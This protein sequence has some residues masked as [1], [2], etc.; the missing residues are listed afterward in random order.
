[1]QTYATVTNDI[2]LLHMASSVLKHPWLRRRSKWIR[3][4]LMFVQKA[5]RTIAHPHPISL[6]YR[7]WRDRLIFQRFW[8]A[9][10]LAV[11][12]M[13]IQGVA[14][15]Y[16]TFVNPEALLKNLE[17]RKLTYLLETFRQVFILNKVTTIG[18]LGLLILF[19]NSAWGRKYPSLLVILFP[20]AFSFLPVMVLS[21][22][23]GI[24]A[25]PDIIMFMAQVAILPIHWR[26]HLV[27]QVV[28]IAFYFIVYPLIGLDTFGGLTIYSFSDTAAIILV[29]IIC[30]VGVYLYEQSKQSEIEASRRLQLCTHAI[31][32]D[33]RTPVMG[34]LM[35]LES[36][37]QGTPADESIQISQTEMSHLIQ[38][39]DRLLGL[40]N[41]LLDNQALSQSELVLN[42]KPTDLSAI[43]AT[44]VQDFQPVL[45]KK[46][47]RLDN[48]I[49]SNLPTVN[50]DAQQI[51]RVL[52]NLIANA[53]NHNPPGVHLALD[54]TVIAGTARR[55]SYGD[56]MRLCSMLKVIV[57][58]NGVGIAP[59]QQETIFE[60]YTR[61]QQSQ[62]QPGLGLGLYICRQVVQAHGGEIGLE[63]LNQGTTFWFTLPLKQP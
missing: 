32:H 41:T 34:S 29:C 13:S 31:T 35:L 14:M 5:W 20:W 46:H 59:V 57:R 10:G 19:R 49:R 15:Y 53:I 56:T 33:L 26:L 2:C 62:Y 42:L 51:W 63:H 9:I 37:Q 27:A 6:E 17:L 47:V 25:Y 40:M 45:V 12:F 21:A 24:P 61:A 28:P 55:F 18:L 7:R 60:P 38:G 16:E 22:F 11:A 58:D 54:A 39:Y 8:L 30:E 43:A 4:A 44:I 48:R 50:V 1:M 36:I 52:C 23:A 3:P